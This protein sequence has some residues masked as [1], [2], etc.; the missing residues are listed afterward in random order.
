MEGCVSLR[1]KGTVKF[2]ES[3]INIKSLGQPEIKHVPHNDQKKTKMTQ[4]HS[5]KNSG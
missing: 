3:Q 2:Y 1:V 5:P 4:R